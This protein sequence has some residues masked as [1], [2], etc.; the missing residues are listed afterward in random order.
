MVIAAFNNTLHATQFVLKEAIFTPQ[1][2]MGMVNWIK[3]QD[4]LKQ[5]SLKQRKEA[6]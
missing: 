5:T 6:Y 4:D 2:H 3:D 1:D